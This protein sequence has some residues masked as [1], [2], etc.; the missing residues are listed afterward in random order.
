MKTKYYIQTVLFIV[1][2]CLLLIAGGVL[3][4]QFTKQETIENQNVITN[5]GDTD[6]I[7][8]KVT[9][10]RDRIIYKTKAKEKGEVI[11]TIQRHDLLFNHLFSGG[12]CY[13]DRML[14][15]TIEY[16]YKYWNYVYIGGGITYF[17]DN[18]NKIYNVKVTSGF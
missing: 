18:K 10:Y 1:Y 16:N 3:T 7:K 17:P 9:K 13:Y 12:F 15:F 4:Y 5:K 14:G 8:V 11:T 6:K 2:S